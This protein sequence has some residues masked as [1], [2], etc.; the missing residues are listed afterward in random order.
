MLPSVDQQLKLAKEYL[1]KGDTGAAE[2]LFRQILSQFPKD[3]A[4]LAG[5]KN[6]LS[7]QQKDKIPTGVPPQSAVQAVIGLY[8]AGRLEDAVVHLSLIHI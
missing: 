4:A 5:L 7:Q 6:L 3:Q 1:A 8:N 2:D